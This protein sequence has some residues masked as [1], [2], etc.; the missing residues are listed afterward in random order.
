MNIA[1][2]L[3]RPRAAG[4]YASVPVLM[5]LLGLFSSLLSITASEIFYGAALAAW[6]L[7]LVRRRES[8]PIPRSFVPLV[9]YAAWSLLASATSVNPAI[10]IVDD[11][12]LV[13]LVLVPLV[14]TAFTRATE[15]AWA[16]RAVLASAA[17]SLAWSYLRFAQSPQGTRIAG[18]M[19]HYM[20]QAGLLSLFCALALAAF[21]VLRTRERWAWGAAFVGACGALVMTLTRSA[22]IGLVAVAVVVLVATRPKWLVAVPLVAALAF[23]A[24]PR[25]VKQRA[26]SIFDAGTAS[27]RT[28]IEYFHAGVM[29]AKARP[30]FGTGPATVQLEFQNPKYGLS[31]EARRNV[32]LHNNLTQ[33]AAERGLPA[34]LFWLGFMVWT[35][36]DLA[37][38][39]GTGGIVTRW[40]A[41]AGMAAIAALFVA[42]MFEYNFGDSE[43]AMLFLVLATAPFAAARIE[44]TGA[45]AAAG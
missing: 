30:L 21:A 40:A 28:R 34:L 45:G 22:W 36:V 41:V 14:Y 5:I 17:V 15:I 32:H 19:G 13:L 42:G 16:Y 25:A 8:P 1:S 6:A 20:T 37:R 38:L 26:L 35:F 9:L 12:D 24:A 44:S 10:S 27:N 23:F 39:R 43:V 2:A 18:F 29:I 3:S 4:V 11:R 31:E 7:N 33:I